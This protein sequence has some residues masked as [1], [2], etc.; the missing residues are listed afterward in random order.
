MLNFLI[1]PGGGLESTVMN[2][3]RIQAKDRIVST[4]PLGVFRIIRVDE[5]RRP[6]AADCE[7]GITTN[8]VFWAVRRAS[9]R[10][11]RRAAAA[12]PPWS[13]RLRRRNGA[14]G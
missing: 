12:S 3:A 14:A 13:G 11:G 10:S 5:G 2:A 7:S 8:E 1:G 4:K 9:A 6:E